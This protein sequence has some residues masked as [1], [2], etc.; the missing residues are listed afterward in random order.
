MCD[1]NESC[2][3]WIFDVWLEWIMF[4]LNFWCVTWMIDVPHCP[5]IWYSVAHQSF[6]SHMAHHIAHQYDTSI[7]YIVHSYT[8]WRIHTWHSACGVPRVYG[9]A[10]DTKKHDAAQQGT[11]DT[12]APLNYRSLLQRALQKRWY[13]AKETYDF[14]E[15]TQVVAV[16]CTSMRAPQM[17]VHIGDINACTTNEGTYRWHQCVHHTT[18]APR[19]TGYLVC[20]L[21]LCGVVCGRKHQGVLCS[22]RE[23]VYIYAQVCVCVCVCV[24]AQVSAMQKGVYIYSF[25]VEMRVRL[26][27]LCRNEGTYR[28]SCRNG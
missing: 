22:S 8:A 6:K 16:A 11:G 27:I 17:R 4:D 10:S 19:L 9:T 25:H 15:P 20:V 28:W 26:L 1:L 3:T 23:W 14:K 24:Y 21:C 5:S 7:W 2:L 18:S 13:S 12:K